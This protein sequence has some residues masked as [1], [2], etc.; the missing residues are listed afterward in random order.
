MDNS[1]A[2]YLKYKEK[3]INLKTQFNNN[4]KMSKLIGGGIDSENS[5]IISNFENQYSDEQQSSLSGSSSIGL[6]PS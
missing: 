3:Y 5:K 2:K 1:Y 4:K 6:Q